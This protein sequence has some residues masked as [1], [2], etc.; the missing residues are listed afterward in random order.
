MSDC[1]ASANAAAGIANVPWQVNDFSAYPITFFADILQG[2]DFILP[3][4]FYASGG[5]GAGEDLT[6]QTFALSVDWKFYERDWGWQRYLGSPFLL[7]SQVLVGDTSGELYFNIPG[8]GASGLPFL[9]GWCGCF[10]EPCPTLPIG[11]L[12]VEVKRWFPSGLR[13]TTLKGNL[14]VRRSVTFSAIPVLPTPA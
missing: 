4:T 14:I 5:N 11:T 7:Y 12:A 8:Y 2:D 9:P 13:V 3:I 6:G 10:G 1:S